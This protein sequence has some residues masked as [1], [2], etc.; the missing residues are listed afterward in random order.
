MITKEQALRS[1]EFHAGDCRRKIGPKGGVK[2]KIE[3]W[4]A[5]GRCHIWKT[6][7]NDFSLPLRRGLYNFGLVFFKEK[8]AREHPPLRQ[9]SG[10]NAHLFHTAE[11]CPLAEATVS[12]DEALKIS[13]TAKTNEDSWPTKKECDEAELLEEEEE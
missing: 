13:P 3:A 2:L 1:T 10:G 5:N 7:P 8:D 9:I 4:K 6:R 11:D 12:L